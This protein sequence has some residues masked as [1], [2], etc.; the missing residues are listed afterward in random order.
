MSALQRANPQR[1]Q[2]AIKRLPLT[3][4]K[5]SPDPLAN[6]KPSKSPEKALANELQAVKSGIRD[7]IA[8]D[9]ERRRAAG[10]ADDHFVVVFETGAQASAFLRGIGYRWPDE[11]FVDG[12][13]V[14]DMLG[15]EI[16]KASAKPRELKKI[17]D[18]SLTRLVNRIK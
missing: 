1:L 11:A 16:P 10:D 15:I 5:P 18:Q 3:W 13:I 14:A 9:N 6:V 4:I 2:R 12:T 8:K 17:H 7:R